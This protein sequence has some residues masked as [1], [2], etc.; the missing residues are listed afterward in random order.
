[1]NT[2]LKKRL[3]AVLLS[4]VFVLEGSSAHAA[5]NKKLTSKVQG[6]KKIVQVS[7]KF[8]ISSI[9]SSISGVQVI[10]LQD[11]TYIIISS[12]LSDSELQKRLSRFKGIKKIQNPKN[13][14]II[15]PIE[16]T[17][18][19]N[20]FNVPNTKTSEGAVL[21]D[22]WYKYEWDIGYTESNKAWAL[23]NQKRQI[24]VAVVDT[25][26]DYNH[27]DLKNRVLKDLG[28]NFISNTSDAMDDN[29]HGTHVAGIIAAEANNKQ[30]VAG[31]TGSLDVKIIPVKV[32]NSKGEG[33]SDVIAK[34]IEYAA[35]K[36]ADIIN[37]SFGCNE[38]STDIENAIQYARNKGAFIVAAAGNDNINCDNSSPAGDTGAY[39]VAAIDSQYKK[40]SFSDYGNSVKIAAPGMKI[41][42]TVP[43]NKYEAWDGTSMAAPVVSGVAAMVK[44]ENPAITP[45]E[46]ED[47]LDK[48]AVDIMQKGKDKF[49]GYGLVDAYKAIQLEKTMEK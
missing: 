12:N 6:S 4:F 43:G 23:V 28:Y 22:Q 1:M 8:D 42:S 29:S 36:G 30:G 2:L 21:N 7:N 9:K 25:G 20:N 33:E 11:G 44:A 35:D 37:L 40:A 32:L 17:P 26:V 45:S 41:V 16:K 15:K 48:S 5:A 27:V 38:D 39:T 49:T 34:G 13:I 14:G 46:M 47:I 18:V 24:K 10:K 3:G 31:I 19:Q